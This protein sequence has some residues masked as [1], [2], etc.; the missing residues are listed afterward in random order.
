MSDKPGDL[1]L[2]AQ[3]LRDDEVGFDAAEFTGVGGS[4]AAQQ[5]AQKS[6]GARGLSSSSSTKRPFAS[7]LDGVDEGPNKKKK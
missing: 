1:E 7:I 4:F 3:E 5:L 6:A 2:R